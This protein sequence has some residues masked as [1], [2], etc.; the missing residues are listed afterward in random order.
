MPN[1][2]GRAVWSFTADVAGV[3][4]V[5]ADGQFGIVAIGPG[6]GRGL[7]SGILLGLGL[8]LVSAVSAI[9]GIIVIAVRRGNS[10]RPHQ[11]VMLHGWPGAAPPPRPPPR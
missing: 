11:P 8:I 3:Y 2:D 10:G 7:V 9:V 5:T 4:T 6:L 1:H